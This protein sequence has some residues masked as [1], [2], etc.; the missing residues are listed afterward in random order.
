SIVAGPKP[1]P[2]LRPG[3]Y[4]RRV[5]AASGECEVRRE[6]ATTYPS[7]GPIPFRFRPVRA[8]GCTGGRAEL[9]TEATT[10]RKVVALTF[11]DGPSEYTE[12]FLVV[13]REK[14]VRA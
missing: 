13:L 9:V 12:R 8:V 1:P 7:A 6:C 4:R 3:R 5:L 14:D 10:E 11:D 2:G